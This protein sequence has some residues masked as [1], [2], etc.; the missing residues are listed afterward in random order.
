MGLCL[1][2]GEL[3]PLKLARHVLKFILNRPLRWL[4]LQ[5]YDPV[6]WESLRQLLTPEA[7]DGFF[8]QMDMTFTTD[9]TVEETDGA[10]RIVTIPLKEGGENI[11]VTKDNVVEYVYKVVEL[12]LLGPDNI[13]CYSVCRI[14]PLPYSNP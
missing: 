8:Q 12:K 10:L 1:S 2:Q 4:D 3:F 11:P 9:I 5:F 6:L 7:K 13:Q 14:L